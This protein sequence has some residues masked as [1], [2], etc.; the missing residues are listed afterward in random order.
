M[1]RMYSVES[2]FGGFNFYDEN[3]NFTGYSV[4]DIGIVKNS[5]VKKGE[6]TAYVV[7]SI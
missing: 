4:T 1:N 3:G 2:A 7:S 6:T 5:K